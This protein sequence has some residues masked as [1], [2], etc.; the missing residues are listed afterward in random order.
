MHDRI[1]VSADP[2]E[3][4]VG[5]TNGAHAL[6]DLGAAHHEQTP[7]LERFQP[8]TQ[9]QAEELRQRHGEIR[10]PVGIDRE[11]GD[12]ELLMAHDAFEGA[13]ALARFRWESP[14]FRMTGL[15]QASAAFHAS[16]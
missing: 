10:V 7:I 8:R 4:D 11:L 5:V 9:V 2:L 12:L 16:Q 14:R 15:R 1:P 6:R 3:I 13:P